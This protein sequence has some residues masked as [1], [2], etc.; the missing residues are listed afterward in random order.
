MDDSNAANHRRSV[1]KFRLATPADAES[2]VLLIRSAYRGES[3]RQGWTSEA[4]LVEGDRINAEQVLARIEEPNS[5]MLVFDEGKELA[6]P[7]I[8]R[9]APGLRRRHRSGTL[10]SQTGV[11]GVAVR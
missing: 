10:R 3:S 8:S 5:V 2:L 7:L 9:H 6:A 4:D 1:P 11:L